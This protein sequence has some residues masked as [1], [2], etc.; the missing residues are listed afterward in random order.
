MKGHSQIIFIVARYTDCG[1][2]PIRR[3]RRHKNNKRRVISERSARSAK[4]LSRIGVRWG[5]I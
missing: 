2:G 3:R 1:R 5:S 4:G